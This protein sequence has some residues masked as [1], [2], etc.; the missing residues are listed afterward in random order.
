MVDR[1]AKASGIVRGTLLNQLAGFATGVTILKPKS[2]KKFTDL[3]K[4]PPYVYNLLLNFARQTWPDTRIAND[5]NCDPTAITF[6]ADHC[7][8]KL[9]FISKGG[10]RYESVADDRTDADQI[11]CVNF[12]D[13]R[14]PCRILYH[15]E[16]TVGDC[17]PVICSIVERLQADDRIPA[18]PWSM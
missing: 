13:S 5:F 4:L 9:P 16:L 6:A 3:R 12:E 2:V 14:T 11:A 7:A 1:I 17:T 10:A 8:R 18:F 15:F